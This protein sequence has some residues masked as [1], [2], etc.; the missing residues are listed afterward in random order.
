MSSGGYPGDDS[1]EEEGAFV[2]CS[3]WL[4]ECFARQGRIEEARAVFD[5]TISTANGLG[6]FAEQ[7][8]PERE[9]M[10]GNFPQALSHLSHLEAALAL[11][12]TQGG[13][14]AAAELTEAEPG[15]SGAGWPPA[16]FDRA[17]TSS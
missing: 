9:E 8:D 4:A 6:L 14:G 16:P 12:E 13:P 5:R 7:Y 1:P 15:A 2:A 11:A 17:R 10:L 3:F